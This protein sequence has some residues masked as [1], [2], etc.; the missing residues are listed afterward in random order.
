MMRRVIVT[1]G[2]GFIGR[3]LCRL[4]V[5]KG[6]EVIVLSRNPARVDAVLG[7][8]VKGWQ[9]DAR[10]ADGW[11]D[12]A[13]GAY[14]IVNLAG[15]SIASGKWTTDKK[16][17]ILESRLNAGQ[18]VREAIERVDNRPAVVIQASAIG[19]YGDGGDEVLNER[20]PRGS[21]FLAEVAERWEETTKGIQSLGVRHVVIRTAIVLGK[22]G[23]FL[24]NVIPPFKMFL[25]GPSGSGRQWVS[26][27]HIEDEAGA[28]A[29]LLEREDL[30]GIFNL[31]S[32]NPTRNRDFYRSLGRAIK[33]PS[34]LRAPGLLLRMLLGEMAEELI[35][36]GQRVLPERLLESGYE[37]RYPDL[38]PAFQEIFTVSPN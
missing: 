17:R 37:F 20:C 35:L 15:D 18:A 22:G 3:V 10:T 16:R 30:D 13:D 24:R 32:P 27:I 6:Y 19:Y 2:T 12:A 1:G 4:L 34:W 5:G 28:V 23:G 11:A 8:G 29:F 36:A 33:R 7:N 9:W 21:G 25:G 26:W 38:D 31:S 14:G